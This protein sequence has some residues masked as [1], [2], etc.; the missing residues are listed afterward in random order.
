MDSDKCIPS[1]YIVRIYTKSILIIENGKTEITNK[2]SKNNIALKEEFARRPT[3]T[4]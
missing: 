2:V 4:D 3:I 1:I